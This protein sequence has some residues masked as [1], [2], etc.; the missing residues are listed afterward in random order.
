MNQHS[1]TDAGSPLPLQSLAK[2]FASLTDQ[3]APRG[4]R[5][6]LLPLLWIV[7]LAKL[8]GADTPVAIADWA[9]ERAPWLRAQLHL[10]WRRMPHHSTYRRLFQQA[11][12]L[13]EFEQQARAFLSAR[14]AA[15]E[16]LCN[17]DGK[18][19][20][21]TIPGGATQGLHLLALQQAG[22]NLVL[23][24]RPVAAKKNEISTAPGLL[25]DVALHG[26]IISGDALHAQRALS[27]Q[28]VNGG[29]DY[30]WFVKQNQPALYQQL[31]QA[32]ADP[33]PR[34]HD[35][36]TAQAYDKGHGRR[37]FRQLTSSAQLTNTLDW[38][39]A[40]QAFVLRRERTDCRTEKV[41]SQTVYGIT[42]LVPFAAD[43]HRLLHLT[44]QQWS[45]ENGL[46]Y[47]RDVTFGEDRCRMKSRA[48]AE[49]LAIINNLAIGLLRWLGW[50][51]LARARRY[52]AAHLP[53]ALQLIQG[54][55]RVRP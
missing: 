14:Q 44:R 52:Y 45:I 50:D 40:A 25:K 12:P 49:C 3:R 23:A 7:L 29:G 16:A 51:N 32:W 20:R 17:L 30:L 36:V 4:V 33:A 47:R 5:Y 2:L 55:Q 43:A 48:A 54:V 15:D 11:L 41:T 39:F 21:G 46:H 34:P 19:L 1:E 38:P 22:T 42:S 28:I 18:T 53:Q 27:R 24:Q 31:A 35:A 26:K 6:G 8:M 13:A 37:E 10:K 9:A